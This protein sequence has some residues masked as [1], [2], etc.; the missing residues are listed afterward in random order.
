M[1]SEYS[2]DFEKLNNALIQN[3]EDTER[4]IERFFE[5]K[6]DEGDLEIIKKAQ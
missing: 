4:A 3:G 2:Y 5:S 6:S 1:I